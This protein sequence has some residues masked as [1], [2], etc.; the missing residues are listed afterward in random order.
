MHAL[1]VC[2]RRLEEEALYKSIKE[3]QL[4][5]QKAE[6]EKRKKEEEEQKKL[7]EL[8]VMDRK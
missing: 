2:F 4:I 5:A 6:E 7:K 1:H 3:A 8:Q